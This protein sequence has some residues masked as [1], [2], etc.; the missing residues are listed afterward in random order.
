MGS[1]DDGPPLASSVSSVT[2]S[3]AASALPRA[4][5]PRRRQRGIRNRQQ[6]APGVGRRKKINGRKRHLICDHR[7]LVLLVMVTPADAQDPLFARELLFRWAKKYLDITIKTVRRPPGTGHERGTG[8]PAKGPHA[9]RHWGTRPGKGPE[10]GR[11][12]S[13]SGDPASRPGQAPRIARHQG[14]AVDASSYEAVRCESS[15][16]HDL[17][18]RA[19]RAV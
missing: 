16:G 1:P 19:T 9:R 12:R 3:A 5:H 4:K 7:G 15:T 6:S 17:V 10:T 2:S 11:S 14:S 18:I 8:A 13:S